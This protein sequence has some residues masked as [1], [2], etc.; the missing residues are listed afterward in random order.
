MY[1]VGNIEELMAVIELI[2]RGMPQR[3]GKAHNLSGTFC[4]FLCVIFFIIYAINKC[5][6]NCLHN[7]KQQTECNDTTKK[8]S[9]KAN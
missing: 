6:Y 8:Q 1:F 2:E 4:N 5:M 7:L 3:I 9:H